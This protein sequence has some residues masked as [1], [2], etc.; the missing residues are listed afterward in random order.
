MKIHQEKQFVR[1]KC[2]KYKK[3]I[4][5]FQRHN[6]ALFDWVKIVL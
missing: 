1:I 6:E 2:S 3:K 4:E 5:F